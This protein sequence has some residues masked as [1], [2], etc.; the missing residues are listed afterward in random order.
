MG[1]KDFLTVWMRVQYIY[2]QGGGKIQFW[3]GCMTVLDRVYE[4][5][6]VLDRMQ[7]ETIYMKLLTAGSNTVLDRV[8]KKMQF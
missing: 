6:I 8:E 2:I 5:N 1:Y 4:Q 3:T 7:L